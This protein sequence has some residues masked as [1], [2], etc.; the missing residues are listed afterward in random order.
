FSLSLYLTHTHKHTHT[1]QPLALKHLVSAEKS[2]FSPIDSHEHKI[3][4]WKHKLICQSSILSS[5]LPSSSLLCSPLALL[6]CFLYASNEHFFLPSSPPPA[7][8]IP[9]RQAGE[10]DLSTLMGAGASLVWS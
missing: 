1:H 8:V 9:R 2:T 3:C 6:H 7:V 5:L 10:N 4:W